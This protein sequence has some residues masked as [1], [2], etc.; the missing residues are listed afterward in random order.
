MGISIVDTGEISPTCTSSETINFTTGSDNDNY[1]IP[2]LELNQHKI[3]KTVFVNRY[4][5]TWYMFVFNEK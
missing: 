4:Q 3:K 2:L 5:V 1:L